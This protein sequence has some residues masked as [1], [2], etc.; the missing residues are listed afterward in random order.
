M[1][2]ETSAYDDWDSIQNLFEQIGK[3]IVLEG[4]Y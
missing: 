2:I 3:A 1:F 4:K